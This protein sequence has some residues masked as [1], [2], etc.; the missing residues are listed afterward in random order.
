MSEIKVQIT[1]LNNAITKLQG[2]RSRYESMDIVRPAPSGGGRTVNE[3]EDIAKVYNML[4][5]DFKE[6][7]SN[8][9][10]FFQN[11]CDSYVLSDIKAAEGINK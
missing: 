5:R 2:L 4:D 3:I 1:E 10:S 7:I 11:V 6:L 8:T 9:I